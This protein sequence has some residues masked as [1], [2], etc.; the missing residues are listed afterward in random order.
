MK[1]T[2][3]IRRKIYNRDGWRCH[4]CRLEILI[5][6]PHEHPQ[7]ATV[8]HKTPKSRGGSDEN[9]NLLACCHRCNIEK[10]D[11]PYEIYRWFRHMMQRGHCRL[12][13]LE[14]I[15]DATGGSRHNAELETN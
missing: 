11:I 5:G 1:I 10:G 2:Y 15:E 7:R 4:Y 12:E 13:L 14:A 9:R 8:D 6:V 3:R